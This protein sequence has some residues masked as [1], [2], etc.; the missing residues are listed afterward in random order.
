[1]P[2]PLSA[3]AAAHVKDIAASLGIT[4]MYKGAISIVMSGPPEMPPFICDSSMEQ[5]LH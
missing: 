4:L 5:F 2:A 1:L 3:K